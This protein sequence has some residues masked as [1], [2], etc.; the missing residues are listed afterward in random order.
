MA[1][2]VFDPVAFKLAFP[3]F[4]DVP[5]ARLTALFGLIGATILD[6]TDASIVIDITQRAAMLDLV[7]AHMLT[8]F[9]TT[10]AGSAGAGP[11]GVV[12]RLSS[13]TEGTVSSSFEMNVPASAGS[14]WWNQTQYGAL[15]WVLMAPF[16][17]FRYV[18]AGRSGVGQA[19]DFLGRPIGIQPRLTNNS[20]TPGGV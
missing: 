10:V 3:E 4:A 2:V 20:G 11:S 18:P 5:D 1:V 6:N 16:R 8:L 9:G 12:G 19:L 15:Y 7:L 17:S 14:A 13:A